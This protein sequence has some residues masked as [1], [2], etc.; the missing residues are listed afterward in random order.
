MKSQHTFS[1]VYN[2]A[3]A[4]GMAAV[5]EMTPTPMIVGTPTTLLGNEI[6]YSKK[7]YCVADGVCGFAWVNVKPG[8]S[9]FA[10]WLKKKG[11]ARKDL[12]YG[13]VTVWVGDFNQSYERKMA[14]ASGF[15]ATLTEAGINANSN[16]RLD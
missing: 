6:D 7:T 3:H 1:T 9:A 16:G 5:K 4:N 10:K 12:Y 13:G 14:Y 8:T 15:A 11:Y 2:N